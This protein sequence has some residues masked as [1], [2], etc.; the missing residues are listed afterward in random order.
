M[1]GLDLQEAMELGEQSLSPPLVV[2]I[3]NVHPHTGTHARY[4]R[5]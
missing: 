5:L 3:Q 4:Y 2:V 1:G